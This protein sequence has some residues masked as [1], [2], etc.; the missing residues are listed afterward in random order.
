MGSGR[1]AGMELTPQRNLEI[2][3][4]GTRSFFRDVDALTEESRTRA[5]KAYVRWRLGIRSKGLNCEKLHNRAGAEYRSI[6][7]SRTIRLLYVERDGGALFFA[8]NLHDYEAAEEIDL[9]SLVPEASLASWD[10]D[11]AREEE[12]RAEAETEDESTDAD[13]DLLPEDNPFSRL[14]LVSD[15]QMLDLGVLW[16]D[17]GAVRNLEN[18][19]AL[20]DLLETR[21]DALP[22]NELMTLF[23]SPRKDTLERLLRDRR[24]AGLVAPAEDV[25]G[26]RP[27]ALDYWRAASL[28]RFRAWLSPDQRDAVVARAPGATVVLGAAGTGKTAVALHRAHFLARAVFDAPGDRILLTTF[29]TTLAEDLSRRLDDVCDD[30]AVRARIDV[31]AVNDAVAAFLR[32]NGVAADSGP[33]PARDYN[34]RCDA[35]MKRAAAEAGYA[36]ARRPGWLRQEY[37]MAIDGAGIRRESDYVGRV[38][39]GPGTKPDDAEKKKLW[40]V[41]RR[42]EA[43]AEAEG[44]RTYGGAA[45]LAVRMLGGGAA[46]PATRYAAAVA[47]ET[48][49]LSPPHLRFLAAVVGDAPGRPKPDGLTF[50]G[51]ARQRIFDHGGSIRSAGIS[52]CDVRRLVRNYR[53]TEEIRRRAE[54]FLEGV[55]FDDLDGDLVVRDPSPAVRRG[56]PVEEFRCEDDADE[57]AK[58]AETIRRWID[59]DSRQPGSPARRP[60]EYAVLSPSNKRVEI[61]RAELEKRGVPAVVV[62]AGETPGDPNR[63]RVMTMHRAKGLEYQGVALDLNAQNWPM[64]PHQARTL[65]PEEI[66]RRERRARCLA[67]AALTRAIR[68]A[69]VTGVGPAP[70]GV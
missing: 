24:R 8:A 50:V 55:P 31:L 4:R 29:S 51:D 49:D 54:R 34:A 60:G 11:P 65:P 30:P 7:G 66:V 46:D 36:G 12:I 25:D 6:R 35:L 47:D 27:E 43:L 14:D 18:A 56:P 19:D 62:A 64:S 2:P 70:E 68:R 15:K 5:R 42:F 58:I 26:G 17:V 48:Q 23:D 53:S 21:G 44:F 13:P 45:N 3:V 16:E 28:A 22:G 9:A 57:A 52:V 20:L 63:V 59:E 10:P 41:F 33:G 69:L 1:L 39:P 67:Y 32:A 38:L 40:P 37:E 61:L